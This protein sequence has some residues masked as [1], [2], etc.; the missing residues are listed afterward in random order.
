LQ[1]DGD[2]HGLG[3]V[4]IGAGRHVGFDV[5]EVVGN[6]ATITHQQSAA[7]GT[8]PPESKIE[9]IDRYILMRELFSAY[10]W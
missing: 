9:S 5:F 6:V 3:E 8:P 2:L 10:K 1:R 4:V 7:A